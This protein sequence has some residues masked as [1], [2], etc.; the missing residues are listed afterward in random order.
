MDKMLSVASPPFC[1]DVGNLDALGFGF[2]VDQ[3][4]S[5]ILVVML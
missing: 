2:K 4:C 1:L 3:N 5:N